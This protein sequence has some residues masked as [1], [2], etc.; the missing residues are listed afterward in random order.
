MRAAA[1]ALGSVVAACSS[2]GTALAPADAESAGIDAARWDA[3]PL[4]ALDAAIDGG[5]SPDAATATGFLRFQNGSADVLS[6]DIYV[7]A[8]GRSAPDT[9]SWLGPDGATHALDHTAADAAD[10]LE[11]D[12]VRY[13]NMSFTLADAP[14]VALP[15]EF[16]AGRVYISLG[17]PLYI[18]IGA[19]DQ[20][21]SAPDPRDVADP[22]AGIRYDWYELSYKHGALPLRGAHR[23]ERAVRAGARSDAPADV[24]RVR[25]DAWHR[26]RRAMTCSRHTR[27][28]CHPSSWRCFN[29]TPAA[30]PCA[31]CRRLLR[32]RAR[33]AATSI[34]R[35]TTSG[36]RMRSRRSRMWPLITR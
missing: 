9:W 8:I 14:D 3:R 12:G 20:A 23:A 13:A 11:K 7:T 5:P 22:N 30:P 36:P 29:W 19:D 27:R 1:V 17:E 34:H 24:E 31:C 33:S 16:V 25:D 28:R 18:T 21:W 4:A 6:T 15:P 35:S 10:H 2:R 32:R 26:P